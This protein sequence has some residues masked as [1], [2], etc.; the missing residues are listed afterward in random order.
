[1]AATPQA[2]GFILAPRRPD[3]GHHEEH[4]DGMI[5]ASG[6]AFEAAAVLRAT[7]FMRQL[8]TVCGSAGYR[9]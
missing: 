9:P 7:Q 8:G 4:G 6:S 1:M 2:P 5:A 3:G